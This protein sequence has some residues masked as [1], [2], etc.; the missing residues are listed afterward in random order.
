M[1]R[2]QEGGNGTWGLGHRLLLLLPQ[3]GVILG[4]YWLLMIWFVRDKICE[5]STLSPP[6]SSE[7]SSA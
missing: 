2:S 6:K 7:H 1:V 3:D 5:R 4:A